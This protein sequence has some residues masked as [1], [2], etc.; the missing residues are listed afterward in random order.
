MGPEVKPRH[1]WVIVG[2][3][4]LAAVCVLLALVVVRSAD[5]RQARDA[6]RIDALTDQIEE[7]RRTIENLVTQ[8]GANATAIAALSE[9]IKQLG[10]EPVASGSTTATTPTTSG[11]PGNSPADPPRSDR[12]CVLGVI[13]LP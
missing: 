4:V 8:A 12:P 2:C 1:R 9:Q 13:C 3:A 7:Q 10:G 6:D 5:D 11:T